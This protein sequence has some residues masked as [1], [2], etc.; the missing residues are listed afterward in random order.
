MEKDQ[1]KECLENGIKMLE[2][3]KEVE[4]VNE[5][6]LESLNQLKEKEITVNEDFKGNMVALN[7]EQE[8]MKEDKELLESFRKKDNLISNKDL[9]HFKEMINEN[10]K[11]FLGFLKEK[12]YLEKNNDDSYKI[13][14]NILK[15]E[16]FEDLL[17]DYDFDNSIFSEIRD[18]TFRKNFTDEELLERYNIEKEDFIIY[19]QNGDKLYDSESSLST[20]NLEEY[21]IDI[22]D[23]EYFNNLKLNDVK[24]WDNLLKEELVTGKIKKTSEK[25]ESFEEYTGTHLEEIAIYT[26]METKLLFGEVRQDLIRNSEKGLIS[27]EKVEILENKYSNTLEFIDVKKNIKEKENI[28]LEEKTSEIEYMNNNELKDEILSYQQDIIE[29]VVENEFEK[30]S[31]NEYKLKDDTL[32]EKENWEKKLKTNKYKDYNAFYIF[33]NVMSRTEMVERYDLDKK[34]SPFEIYTKDGDLLYSSVSENNDYDKIREYAKKNL[35]NYDFEEFI[36]EDL[37]KFENWQKI[38]TYDIGIGITELNGEKT[39]IYDIYDYTD[40]VYKELCQEIDKERVNFEEE[41]RLTFKEHINNNIIKSDDILKVFEK[42]DSGND[43][44]LEKFEKKINNMEVSTNKQK[45]VDEIKT[46]EMDIMQNI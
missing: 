45:E 27:E 26:M 2:Q 15:R 20:R 40:P 8:Q 22:K 33:D 37:T 30:I 23:E 29:A 17:W 28:E 5:Y 24:S 4:K 11:D 25:F 41:I 9:K 13:K 44:R 19:S 38:T 43:K 34:L 46:K 3:G 6:I 21:I 18:T 1:L 42:F 10:K 14:D 39:R 31:K 12:D 7:K 36:N 16:N 32:L 35:E